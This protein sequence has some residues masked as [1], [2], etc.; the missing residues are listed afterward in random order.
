LSEPNI[1][2]YLRKHTAYHI[3][4]VLAFVRFHFVLHSSGELLLKTS[5]NNL[6]F[7]RIW[8]LLLMRP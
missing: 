7:F 1:S 2:F 3:C 5:E 8:L 6:S 4:Y